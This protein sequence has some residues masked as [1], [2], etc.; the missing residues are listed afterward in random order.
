MPFRDG[1]GVKKWN[2]GICEW[3]LRSEI[4]STVG[5]PN[6]LPWIWS[7]EEDLF[8]ILQLNRIRFP[9]DLQKIFIRFHQFIIMKSITIE[10]NIRGCSLKMLPK[11]EFHLATLWI[12]IIQTLYKWHS[13]YYKLCNGLVNWIYFST[14]LNLQCRIYSLYCK[15]Y[16]STNRLET[17]Y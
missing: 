8:T 4:A 5:Y 16:R 1:D 10:R 3:S 17:L 15:L 6:S 11:W 12:A 9:W 7:F 13:L 2:L 14:L